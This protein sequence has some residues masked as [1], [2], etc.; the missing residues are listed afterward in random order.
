MFW[1]VNTQV[2]TSSNVCRLSNARPQPPR[3]AQDDENR[4]GRGRLHAGLMLRAGLQ[5]VGCCA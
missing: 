3:K 4:A 1:G 5:D 2:S